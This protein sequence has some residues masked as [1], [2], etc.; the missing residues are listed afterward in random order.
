[1]RLTLMATFIV[2][3]LFVHP[4]AS[5]ADIT[6][7]LV[8]WWQFE[9]GAG[10][11]ASETT[12]T[13]SAGTLS[14]GPTWVAGHI[15]SYAIHFAGYPQFVTVPN[16]GNLNNV[17]TGTV[18]MWV[19][20]SGT[21]DPS[22]SGSNYGCVLS[23]QSNGIFSNDI[24]CLSN[25]SPGSGVI[26]W[27]W[28]NNVT[29]VTSGTHVVG[30][31]VWRHVVV[32]FSGGTHSIYMDGALEASGSAAGSTNNNSAIPLGIGSWYGDG[33]SSFSGDIDD[34]RVYNRALTAGDVAELFAD[35]GGVPTVYA[36]PPSGLGAGRIS[37]A[38]INF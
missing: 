27:L 20:W 31:N 26:V 2:F 15:G 33:S 30:D 38:H 12:G 13:A 22:F 35:G 9:D 36:S 32:T 21:Q 1:M 10:T 8:S 6:T 4:V 28:T 23:R 19:R 16:G 37:G 11:T 29:P 17:S 34:V 14:G 18:S 7:G 5:H 24:I 3:G 25:T